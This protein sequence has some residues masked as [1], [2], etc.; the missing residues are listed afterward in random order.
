MID[1]FNK[2]KLKELEDEKNYYENVCETKNK[3]INDLQ[4][5]KSDL[6]KNMNSLIKENQKLIEWI[7]K[8]LEVANTK[9]VTDIYSSI[10]IPIYKNKSI[11]Y[12]A[13]DEWQTKQEVTDIFIPQIHFKIAN[14]GRY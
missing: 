1:I 14:G 13:Y 4:K 11:R 9:E 2:K 8:I 12:S 10:T 5:D 7:Q 3:T 6:N